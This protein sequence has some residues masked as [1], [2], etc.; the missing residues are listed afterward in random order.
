VDGPVLG[1]LLHGCIWT[2]VRIRSEER[3]I[4]YFVPL[5][6]VGS[7]RLTSSHNITQR[8]RAYTV[9]RVFV[10]EIK[11]KDK[12]R[13]RFLKYFKGH[14]HC[15]RSVRD[16]WRKCRMEVSFSFSEGVLRATDFSIEYDVF[17]SRK[18]ARE[19]LRGLD[20]LALLAHPHEEDLTELPF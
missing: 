16:S 17:T 12:V 19:H 6:W 9:Q 8:Y 20:A 15:G 1:S 14:L 13:V 3:M 5:R 10:G 18:K 4:L 7:Q 11:C 2:L